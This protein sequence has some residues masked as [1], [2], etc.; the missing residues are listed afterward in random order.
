MLDKHIE[1]FLEFLY[2]ERRASENTLRA[3]K[4]DLDEFCSYMQGKGLKGKLSEVDRT[5]IRTYLAQF[6]L[7]VGSSHV[8]KPSTTSRKLA[9]LRSFFKYLVKTRVLDK[10]PAESI[11]YP[12]LERP[13][14]RLLKVDEAAMFLDNLMKKSDT[15]LSARNWAIFET[16]YST[17][18]RVSELA[19][20]NINDLDLDSG[21]VR[22]FGKGKKER[23]VPLTDKSVDALKGYLNLRT[24]I[25]KQKI[26][27]ALFLNNKGGRL[28][29][30]G[31]AYLLKKQLLGISG[32]IQ[33]SPHGLRHSF[34]TH[35]LDMG[36]D[37]RS[38]QELLGH[39]S[40]STTQRYTHVSADHITRAYDNAHPR[41]RKK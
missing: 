14:P 1:N 12:K 6:T 15:P 26:T 9:T 37:L 7:G 22:A 18:L 38:I 2:G 40:L 23:I 5:I 19:G 39:E 11:R 27:N 31:I 3:Y 16:L 29:V 20:L 24:L 35:L 25:K 34:A 8:L 33:A 28:T 32:S 21:F 10:N 41:A 30:R 13:L 17:G 36:V 4:S